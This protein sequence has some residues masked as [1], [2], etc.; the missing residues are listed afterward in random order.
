V[1][2]RDDLNDLLRA[3]KLTESLRWGGRVSLLTQALADDSR[4]EA[5]A[6]VDVDTRPDGDG[7]G[8]GDGDRSEERS[9]AGDASPR[10]ARPPRGGSA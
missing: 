7:D 10:A 3:S 1:I 9:R 2:P 5:L 8:D 4:R 6:D